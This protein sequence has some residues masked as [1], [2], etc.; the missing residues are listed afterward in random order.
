MLAGDYASGRMSVPETVLNFIFHDGIDTSERILDLGCGTGIST[1]QVAPKA[2]AVVGC[3]PDSA[4]L[5]QAKSSGGKNITYMAG[6][7]T[8][9]PGKDASFDGVTIFSAFHW[10]ANST[11]IAEIFR[12]LR[13]GGWLAIVNRQNSLAFEQRLRAVVGKYA[14]E[15]PPSA[16]LGYDPELILLEGGA[17]DLRMAS[18]SLEE[19]SS[20]SGTLA[21]IRSRSLWNYVPLESRGLAEDHLRQWLGSILNARGQVVRKVEVTCITCIRPEALKE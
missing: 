13:P 9:I 10:F 5:Q 15:L 7:A 16:K 2:A 11:A 19:V 14:L 20:T 17:L 3:D 4:M 12:V 1:R 8:C 21:Y 18:F 6:G